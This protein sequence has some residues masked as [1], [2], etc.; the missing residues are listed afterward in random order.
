[1]FGTSGPRNPVLIYKLYSNMRPSDFSSD[2]H[3]FY[4]A[5]RTIDTASQWFLRQLLG[6]NKLGQMLKAMAKDAGFPEHKR[7]IT[8]SVRK[9]L[10]QKL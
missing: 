5:T 8:H 7:I 1:M 6:V 10:V 2:Q 9:F 4:L 3:P